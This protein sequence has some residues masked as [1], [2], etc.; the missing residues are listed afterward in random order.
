MDDLNGREE[1]VSEA[2]ENLTQNVQQRVLKSAQD[3]YG[4]SLGAPKNHLENTVG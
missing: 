4:N 3:F 2:V 1:A